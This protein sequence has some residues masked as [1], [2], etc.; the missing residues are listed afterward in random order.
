[1]CVLTDAFAGHA[2]SYDRHYWDTYESKRSHGY[3][4]GWCFFFA[5]LACI[6]AEITGVL[7]ITV[8]YRRCQTLA[9][10]IRDIMP[11]REEKSPNSYFSTKDTGCLVKPDEF[12]R[13][14]SKMQP[15]DTNGILLETPPDICSTF[16]NADQ[17]EES[18]ENNV[19]HTK[20]LEEKYTQ[21][22]YRSRKNNFATLNTRNYRCLNYSSVPNKRHSTLSGCNLS[23]DDPSS[24]TASSSNTFSPTQ[25][26][27]NMCIQNTIPRM[28]SC[29]GNSNKY[30]IIEKNTIH[31]ISEMQQISCDDFKL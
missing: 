28:K 20:N 9:Q 11:V 18:T 27:Q 29:T 22:A 15:D 1:M 6:C 8:H 21:C 19:Q 10:I 2:I 24:S 30:H 7:C 26:H 17:T 12:Q 16:L 25:Y 3:K 31:K 5:C 4:Y 23:M 14:E 13:T